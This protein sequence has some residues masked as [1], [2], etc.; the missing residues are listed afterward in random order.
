MGEPS[1]SRSETVVGAHGA[2]LSSS[3]I[4]ETGGL[5][6]TAAWAML[7]RQGILRGHDE[8]PDKRSRA[9]P[10]HRCVVLPVP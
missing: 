10:L 6:E 7:V 3:A 1:S 2:C 8:A 5:Y 4:F 9:Q